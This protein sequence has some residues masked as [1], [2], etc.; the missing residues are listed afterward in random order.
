[1]IK[2]LIFN[3]FGDL[4]PEERFQN[5]CNMSEFRSL[6]DSTSKR[7]LNQLEPKYLTVRKNV[8]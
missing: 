4:K 6:D 1:M 8:V 2:H 3:T 5:R 7:V